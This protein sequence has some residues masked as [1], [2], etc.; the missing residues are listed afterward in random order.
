[1]GISSS[2][3]IIII[4]CNKFHNE[5]TPLP[6]SLKSLKNRKGKIEEVVE[7]LQKAFSN[8]FSSSPSLLENKDFTVF[9]IYEKSIWCG[10]LQIKC[11]ENSFKHTCNAI[12]LCFFSSCLLT[13]ENFIFLQHV[14]NV[15]TLYLTHEMGWFVNEVKFLFFIQKFVPKN[16]H[17]ASKTLMTIA[18][19]ANL[20]MSAR[21]MSHH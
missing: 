4:L 2:E 3:K 10:K 7:L 15:S 9:K 13:C 18:M 17:P 20:P 16:S 12:F 14:F 19:T 5:K 1:M 11:N 8:K 6:T 21:V